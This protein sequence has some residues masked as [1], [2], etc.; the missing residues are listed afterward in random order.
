MSSQTSFN[1]TKV[2]LN[3]LL[4]SSRTANHFGNKRT[5]TTSSSTDESDSETLPNNDQTLFPGSKSASSLSDDDSL[6]SSAHD[7][8]CV[9]RSRPDVLSA[10]ICVYRIQRIIDLLGSDEVQEED[11]PEALKELLES[12]L[13]P[14]SLGVVSLEVRAVSITAPGP[15]YSLINSLLT[16]YTGNARSRFRRPFASSP[17]S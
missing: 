2:Y 17:S 11:K 6:T 13:G 3:A 9:A 4:P 5:S 10:E 14:N 12:F 1:H 8:R 7:I 16:R 15:S